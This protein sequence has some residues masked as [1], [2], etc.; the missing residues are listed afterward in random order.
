VVVMAHLKTKETHNKL[1]E[2]K[3]W[4]YHLTTMLY[5]QGYGEQAIL[6]LD[7]FLDWVMDLPEELEKQ[8]QIELKAFEE[9]RQMKY[10]TTIERM[11]EERSAMAEKQSI[12]INFL[13]EDIPIETIARATGLTIEQLQTLQAQMN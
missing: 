13:K 6:D 12:A 7:N 3:T 9:A 8:F 4:R 10:V 2:R 11:A 5:D 1:E